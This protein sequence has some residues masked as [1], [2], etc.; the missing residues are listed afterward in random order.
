MSYVRTFLPWIVFAV[1]PS[2]QWTWGA[3]A[4]LAAAVALVVR[5]RRDGAD[6]DALFIE[7]GS[8]A[9]FAVLAAIAFADPASAVHGYSAALSSAT[10]ALVAGGSLLIGRPFTLGIAKRGTPREVWGLKAFVRTNTVITAVWTGAFAVT[11]AALAVLSRS[12][13]GHS[14]AATLVQAAGFVV[15][16]LFTTRY[17]A[18]AQARA[19]AR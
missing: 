19:A 11:A 6:F 9:F 7:A 14:A 12:G 8:A 18:S 10:L 17:V 4:A 3:L 15:P 2:A 13:L 16:M 1:V 5:Q